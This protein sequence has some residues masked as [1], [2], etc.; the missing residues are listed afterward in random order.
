MG[1]ENP[2][3]TLGDY[4]SPSHKGYRNTIELPKGNT[5]VPLRFDTIRSVQNGKERACIYFNFLY[6]IK[7]TIS[8]NAFWTTKLCN[9][10]LMFQ[11][12]HGE[13]LSE[14]WTHFKDLLQIV[15]HHGIDLWFQVQIFYDHI[16][17]TTQEG[18]D[19]AAGRRLR[20]LRPDKDWDTIER[21]AQYENKGWN[22]TFTSDEMNFSY[23]NPYVE[24]Y[25]E[26]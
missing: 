24:Q 19:Y 16:E 5:V 14:A 2:I 4:S 12:H 21:L 23:E 3:C 8:L 25:S 10:I 6:E 18:I 26:S 13:S 17:C 9:D 20:K 22:D 7:L 15:P 1:D 11:Q